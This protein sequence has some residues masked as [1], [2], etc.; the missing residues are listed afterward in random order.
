MSWIPII[1]KKENKELFNRITF[2]DGLLINGSLPGSGLMSGNAGLAI[3]YFYLFKLFKKKVYL[4]RSRVLI[5]EAI[6]S[7]EKDDFTFDFSNG[8]SGIFWAYQHL[9]NQGL[10]PINKISNQSEIN[11][12]CQQFC[13]NAFNSQNLDI[14]YGSIGPNILFLEQED[15]HKSYKFVEENIKLLVD[16]SISEGVCIKWPNN[17]LND[18]NEID[19]GMPHGI[20]GILS[21]LTVC[22]K[23]GI[24]RK[25]VFHLIHGCINFLERSGNP[26]DFHSWF[27]SKVG[28]FSPSN[29][30]LSWCYG[31]LTVCKSIWN[32]G[33]ITGKKSWCKLSID[34]LTKSCGRLDFEETGVVDSGICH[35]SFGVAHLYNRVYQR[36]HIEEFRKAG[37]HWFNKYL[38]LE[39]SD[40][41]KS[42]KILNSE[43]KGRD[44][45]IGLLTGSIGIELTLI[46]AFSDISPSWDRCLLL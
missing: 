4:Q 41:N 21:F 29:S 33:A 45:S 35:G 37:I 5:D 46:S 10:T 8:L 38:N 3:Y 28:D 2:T 40:L 6:S 39:R 1:S 27:P 15:A 11:N 36:T 43:N 12:H 24:S 20:S 26:P 31:D 42:L 13:R 32:A 16:S 19:L 7:L 23:K 22:Y 14:L 25:T 17:F 30:R 34:I 9:I 18:S 44:E